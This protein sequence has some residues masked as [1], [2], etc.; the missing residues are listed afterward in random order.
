MTKG[1]LCHNKC[2]G[3]L[4]AAFGVFFLISN[5]LPHHGIRHYWPIFLIAGGLLKAYGCCLFKCHK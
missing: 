5:L 4:L 1:E 3:V 2:W